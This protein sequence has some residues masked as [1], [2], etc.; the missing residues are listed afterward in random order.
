MADTRTIWGGSRERDRVDPT[1]GAVR[2]EVGCWSHART[3]V[4][5]AAVATQN[6]IA[7]EGL[8]RIMRMFQLERIWK[9]R[10]PEEREALRDRHLEPHIASSRSP[11]VDPGRAPPRAVGAGRLSPPVKRGPCTGYIGASCRAHARRT[12]HAR[13]ARPSPASSSSSATLSRASRS[14]SPSREDQDE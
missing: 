6:I 3:G 14:L 1:D 10:A 8:A 7:R 11:G 13:G 4:W 9:D 12:A 5:E 2:H